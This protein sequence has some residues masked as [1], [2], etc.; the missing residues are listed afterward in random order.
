MQNH[1]DLVATKRRAFAAGVIGIA[2]IAML[3]WLFINMS[4]KFFIEVKGNDLKR[5]AMELS[6][7]IDPLEH[8]QIKTLSDMDSPTYQKITAVL[9]NYQ[10]DYPEV[11]AAYTM[12]ISAGRAFFVV[13]PPTDYN[14][15]GIIDGDLEERDDVDEMY[16]H[17]PSHAMSSAGNGI[18]TADKEFTLDRWGTWL[19]A[20]APIKTQ[21]GVLDGIVCTDEDASSVKKAIGK[22]NLATGAL[23]LISAI[24]LSTLLIEYISLR[25]EL[26]ERKAV[27][28]ER[29]SSLR[30]IVNIVDESPILAVQRFGKDGIINLWNKT[31]ETIFG[32][33][34]QQAIGSDIFSVVFKESDSSGWRKII[35]NVWSSKKPS[36]PQKITLTAADGEKKTLFVTIHPVVENGKVT[37][38]FCIGAVIS[39]VA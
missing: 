18:A 37:E 23:A 34:S 13:S 26:G 15:N 19:T 17:P 2:V 12:R 3:A 29:E 21:A 30:K 11:V 39:A 38:A 31:S 33:N 5:L 20:C 8:A 16:F 36:S 10:H 25:V 9:E 24:L 7:N 6:R 32:L 14:K 27:Q 4:R 22:Q 28:N 1:Y 35:E